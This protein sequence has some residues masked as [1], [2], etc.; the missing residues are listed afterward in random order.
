MRYFIGISLALNAFLTMYL[1]GV[2]PFLFYTSILI[3][4]ASF[5]YIRYLIGQ[6]RI[7]LEDIESLLSDIDGFTN[8]LSE[9]YELEMFYGDATLESLITH[10]KQL[11]EN[12]YDYESLIASYDEDA[13]DAEEQPAQEQTQEIHFEQEEE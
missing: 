11:V 9:V 6:R 8:H 10:S 1:F 4:T 7:M 13:D 3:L 2:L 12:I 5:V